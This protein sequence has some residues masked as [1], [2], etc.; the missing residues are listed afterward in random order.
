VKITCIEFCAIDPQDGRNATYNLSTKVEYATDITLG[1][2]VSKIKKLSSETQK[3]CK[4][5][6]RVLV[7]RAD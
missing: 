3:K 1:R 4:K 6:S 2:I 5:L 7:P